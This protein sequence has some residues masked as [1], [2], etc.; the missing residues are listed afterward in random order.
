LAIIAGHEFRTPDLLLSGAGIAMLINNTFLPWYGY[1]ANGW[2]PTYT[3][4][5]SGFLAF[6]PLLIV[7]LIAGTAATRAW[8]GSGLTTV[9]SHE[10]TWNALF[11]VG[12]AVAAL[13][14][15]LFWATLPT[16]DGVSV[17]AKFGAFLGLI[18]VGVQAAGAVLAMVAAGERLPWHSRRAA[19]S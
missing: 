10:V 5:Q 16:L 17:G 1:D 13:F 4:F 3:G 6:F 11:L 9:G 12:D 2:H 18:I 8:N 7:A 19:S 14:I 15:V